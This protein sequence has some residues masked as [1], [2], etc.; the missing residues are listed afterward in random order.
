MLLREMERF[1]KEA[2]WSQ[3]LNK[4]SEAI[5]RTAAKLSMPP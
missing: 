1:S 4:L 5:K 3:G 2:D